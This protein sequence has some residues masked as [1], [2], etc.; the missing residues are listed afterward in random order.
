MTWEKI[1]YRDFYDVPRMFLVRYRNRQFLFDCIFDER[2]DEYGSSYRVM[3][4]PD[5]NDDVLS[6]DWRRLPRI[7]L[8][9]IG[10]VP[11][12][13][14][15]FDPSLRDSVDIGA[16]DALLMQETDGR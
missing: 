8:K 5:L 1:T 12:A 16:I 10:E 3:E 9:L 6:G 13:E 14:V 11:V 7:A 15:R 4:M 2:E